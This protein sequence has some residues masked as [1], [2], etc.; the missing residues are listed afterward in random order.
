MQKKRPF[1]ATVAALLVSYCFSF[2][3]SLSLFVFLIQRQE[4]QPQANGG[5][6]GAGGDFV[7]YTFL[8]IRSCLLFS[9]Y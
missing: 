5:E 1:T 4:A 2:F 6:T 8:Y 9:E 3:L 7:P